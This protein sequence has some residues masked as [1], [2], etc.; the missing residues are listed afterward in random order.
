M[1]IILVLN[2]AVREFK[3]RNSETENPKIAL[4]LTERRFKLPARWQLIQDHKYI[5][6]ILIHL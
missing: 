6:I 3:C 4:Q 2:L 5:E 1:M